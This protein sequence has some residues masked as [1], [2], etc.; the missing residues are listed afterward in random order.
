MN[1]LE[2]PFGHG[3]VQELKQM[4]VVA[5]DVQNAAG[6]ALQSELVPGEDLA[7]L[8]ERAIAAGQGNESIGE[9]GHKGFALVHGPGHAQVRQTAMR[10]L[11]CH[12]VTGHDADDFSAGLQNGI[13]ELAH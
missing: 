3:V 10:H 1:G 12:Q 6:L 7:E 4:V 9:F 2:E 13:R 5:L 8:V 11:A